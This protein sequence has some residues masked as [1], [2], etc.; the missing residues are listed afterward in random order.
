MRNL[1]KRIIQLIVPGILLAATTQLFGAESIVDTGCYSAYHLEQKLDLTLTFGD[2]VEHQNSMVDVDIHVK[3]ISVSVIN[4]D[5]SQASYS[6]ADSVRSFIVLISP[7]TSK[8]NGIHMDKSE[9][10]RNPFLVFMDG[11]SGRLIDLK[12]TVKDPSVL[13]E[14]LSFFDLFQYSEHSGDYHY[15]NGNGHYLAQVGTDENLPGTIIRKNTGYI[16]SNDASGPKIDIQDSFLSITLDDSHSDC[17]YQKGTGKDLFKTVMSKKAFVEGESEIVIE[18]DLK[19]A[20][21]STHFFYTLTDDLALWPTPD[22][23]VTI[24]REQAMERLPDFIFQLSSLTL[25]DPEF[26]RTII[27][28]QSLWPHLADYITESGLTNELSMQLFWALDKIDT[29]ESVA[30][31][32]NLATSALSSR[33]HLRAVLALGSTSAPFGPDSVAL[34]KS[35]MSNFADPEFAQPE[36][37]TY[38]RMLGAMANRRSA[39][40]PVQSSE[41]KNFLYSQAGTYMNESVNAAVIDAI[42]NL[43]SSIDPEGEEILLQSLSETSDQIRQSAAAALKRV[44]Y[45][46]ENSDILISQLEN[47]S[48]IAVKNTIIEVLGKTNNND[49]KVKHQLLAVLDNYNDSGIKKKSLGSLKKID[50]IFEAEDIHRLESR[51][52]KETDKSSQRLLASLILKH[53]RRILNSN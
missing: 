10:Y 13:H 8:V 22:K 17:F 44:P 14:Y 52:R 3:E 7:N 34:L 49:L 26:L 1:M 45:K 37:L 2:N 51:L 27:S 4:P 50:Y 28:E 29:S 33:D 48:N 35:Y 9:R 20:L 5:Q 12:S 40:N 16:E 39:A 43:K 36:S 18:S 53:R 15:R 24:T 11:D 42:G 30:A 41:I 38:V 25:D 23:V 46:P 19:R 32:T 6:T 47:E 31:L 21:P